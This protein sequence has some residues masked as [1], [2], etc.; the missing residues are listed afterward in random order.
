[1]IEVGEYMRTEAGQIV[2]V[3][4]QI[5]SF[6]DEHMSR[7]EKDYVEFLGKIKHSYQLKD[8]LEA[9]DIVNGCQVFIVGQ[10]GCGRLCIWLPYHKTYTEV[11]EEMIKTVM[12]RE[13]VEKESFKNG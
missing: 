8:L 9:G 13:F 3:T 4:H 6:I 7:S 11:E 5:K 1:M 10:A 12:T 2:V